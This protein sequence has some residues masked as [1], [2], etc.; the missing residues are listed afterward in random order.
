MEPKVFLIGAG[1][2]DP[3]LITVKGKSCIEEADVVIYDYLAAPALLKYA[4]KDAEIIYVGKKGGAHTKSQT[5][6]NQLIAL[7]ALENKLFS[8]NPNLNAT[9]VRSSRVSLT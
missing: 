9:S 1:P 2:G 4:R 6:I 3:G 7:K 8:E 5:E